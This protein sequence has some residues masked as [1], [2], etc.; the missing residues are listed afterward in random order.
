M[1]RIELNQNVIAVYI[2]GICPSEK[3]VSLTYFGFFTSL[4]HCMKSFAVASVLRIYGVG[5]VFTVVFEAW[6]PWRVL[7]N[8]VAGDNNYIAAAKLEV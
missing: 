4:T 3:Q 5:V 6:P 8:P 2:F 7:H 1:K